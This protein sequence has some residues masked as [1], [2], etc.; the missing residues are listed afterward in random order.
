MRRRSFL[1][2]SG[3]SALL[4]GALRLVRRPTPPEV[5]DTVL[6]AAVLDSLLPAD[7]D[8]PSATELG[9]EDALGRELDARP[10]LQRTLAHL[11]WRIDRQARTLAGEGFADLLPDR[12]AALLAEIL[13]HDRGL[14]PPFARLRALAFEHYYAHPAV[15]RRL[16]GYHPPQPLGYPDY[17]RPP[18]HDRLA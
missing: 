18:P 7:G 5:P 2:L 14:A 17:T 15:W 9:L 12:R 1:L 11:L 8:W 6:L 10:V 16:P 13:D 3:L 4:L